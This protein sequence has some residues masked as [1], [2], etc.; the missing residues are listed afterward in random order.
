MARYYPRSRGSL[1]LLALCAAS[2]FASG[3]RASQMVVVKS[4]DLAACRSVEQ[5]FLADAG[6]ATVVNL[7]DAAAAA[8]LK[9]AL[10]GA[11]LVL[12]LGVEA[13]RAV[14]SA[15]PAAPVLLALVPDP[16]RAGLDRPVGSVPMFAP[17]A[18]QLK[19]FTTALPGV[20]R[21]GV[22]YDPAVSMDR[23]AECSAAALAEGVTLVSL[24]V[25][26]R[27]EVAAAA[28]ELM[29]K[30]DALWLIPDSTVI[31]AET[32]KFLVQSS[33]ANKVPLLGF[34]EG[35]AKAGALAVVEVSY[36]AIGRS[37]AAWAKAVLAGSAPAAPASPQSSFILNAKSAE[38]LGVMLPQAARNA[39]TKVLE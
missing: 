12:A 39:A 33:I 30:S 19:A 31:S 25:S 18:V 27:A 8:S 2:L 7:A 11:S 3:A 38:L 6:P 32:F 34:S 17:M 1:A 26:S 13:A 10:A 4:T 16:N 24:Q 14:V 28:R 9:D 37:A 21:I 20:K 5:A 15:R 22:L 36:A 29:G 23:A 35:M